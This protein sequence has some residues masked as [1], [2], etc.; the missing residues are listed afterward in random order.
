MKVANKLVNATRREYE[1]DTVAKP[2]ILYGSE[3]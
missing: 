1:Y 2:A 3:I